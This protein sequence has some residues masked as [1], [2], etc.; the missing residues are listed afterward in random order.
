M[1]LNPLDPE[2]RAPVAQAGYAQGQAAAAGVARFWQLP[3]R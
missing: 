1:G 2:I 3:A